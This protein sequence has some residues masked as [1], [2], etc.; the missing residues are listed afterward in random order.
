MNGLKVLKAQ[1]ENELGNMETLLDEASAIYDNE[2][3]NINIRAGG[4]VLHD[5]YTGVENIFQAIASTIDEKVP[6]GMSWNIELLNQMTLDIKNL[7]SHVISRDTATMLE[8]YLRFRHLFR[9]RYGFD[10]DWKSIKKL[11]KGLKITYRSLK[12]DLNSSL[13]TQGSQ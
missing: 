10:L 12:R 11:L 13:K 6:D 8:E 3:S 5:F 7:R 4:S 2:E 1:I 9:K